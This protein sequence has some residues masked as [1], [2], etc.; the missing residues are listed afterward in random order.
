MPLPAPSSP[1]P[2]SNPEPSPPEEASLQHLHT[3]GRAVHGAKWP[4]IGPQLVHTYTNGRTN[5]SSQME[6]SEIADLI[7]ALQQKT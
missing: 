7:N 5:T 1:E 2:V 6:P 4:Q 3:L